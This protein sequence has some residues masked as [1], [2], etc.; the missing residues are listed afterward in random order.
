MRHWRQCPQ[1]LSNASYVSEWQW[2]GFKF[3]DA[4]GVGLGA[5]L[6]QDGRP[7]AFEGKRVTPAEMNYHA[8][9]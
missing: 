6:V 1:R 5:V 9:E 8:G 2:Y 4:C 3:C 7:L